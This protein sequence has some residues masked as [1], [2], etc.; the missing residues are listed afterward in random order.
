MRVGPVR[1]DRVVIVLV[2][3]TMAPSGCGRAGSD[4]RAEPG[5]ILDSHLGLSRTPIARAAIG[6]AY[7]YAGK[8]AGENARLPRAFASAPPVIPHSTG[9][10]LPITLDS[11]TCMDCHGVPGSPQDV[12]P[13]A[14]RSHFVDT[15][16]ATERNRQQ[17]AG[18][19]WLCTSCHVPQTDAPL[20]VSNGSAP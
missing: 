3:L 17:M 4:S 5:E 6:A 1:R 12:P 2:A 9:D 10:L 18:A 11:N 14:P 8:T 19:R 13:P 20:L 16:D 7:A 15:R